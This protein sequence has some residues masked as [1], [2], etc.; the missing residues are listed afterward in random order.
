MQETNMKEVFFG[1]Y[2]K[3]CEHQEVKESED[4]CYDCLN[5]PVRSESHKP[6]KW[7]E[8]RTKGRRK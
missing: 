5:E 1:Q 2:C 6:I 7:E 4:P 8:Q 3:T